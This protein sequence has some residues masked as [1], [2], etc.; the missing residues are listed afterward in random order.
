M[1]TNKIFI[2]LSYIIATIIVFT[3]CNS[4]N[5]NPLAFI[6]PDLSKAKYADVIEISK[7]EKE[8]THY[9]KLG[10]NDDF[11]VVTGSD[12]EHTQHL[13]TK[14]TGEYL[15]S[16]A[17]IGRGPGEYV[18]GMTYVH[19]TTGNDSTYYIVH[20]PLST[21]YTYKVK[22]IMSRSYPFKFTRLSPIPDK[23]MGQLA[24]AEIIPI[25]D[26]IIV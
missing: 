10:I 8:T 15:K 7:I 21:V 17:A 26:R 14:K 2:N 19:F 23:F 20:L 24:F 11:I 13:F 18:M 12:F 3:S 4:G 6:P 9:H 16:F 22:D 1:K 5:V 25:N